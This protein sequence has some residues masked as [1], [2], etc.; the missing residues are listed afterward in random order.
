MTIY[1]LSFGGVGAL[2]A[3]LGNQFALGVALTASITAALLGWQELR[4]VDDTIKD[5]SKVV[6]ELTILSDHWQNLEPE[7]RT[8]AEFYKMV[9][10]CED[11]LW[12][13]NVEYVRSMQEALKEYDTEK[14]A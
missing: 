6:M 13:Q 2:L 7:E 10:G 11:V 1:I 4:K 8:E 5:Y 9:R 14:E 12:T 3:A